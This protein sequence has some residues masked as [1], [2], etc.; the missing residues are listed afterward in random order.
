[1]EGIGM[2]VSRASWIYTDWG[3]STRIANQQMAV[4]FQDE[5][6]ETSLK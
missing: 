2:D 3:I 6:I 4:K 1:M 5:G